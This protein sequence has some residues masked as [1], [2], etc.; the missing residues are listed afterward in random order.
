MI[1]GKRKAD[2]VY[3]DAD[4][5]AFLSDTP[6]V[7]GH[8]IIAP[9]RH[10]PIFEG[11]DDALTGKLFCAANRLSA[12][13]FSAIGAKGTN[14]IVNNGLAA[15]QEI[16]HFCVN[17]ISRQDG[18]GM[19]FDMMP[20]QLSEEEMAEVEIQLREGLKEKPR[21]K[22]EPAKIG[23]D[24]KSH[25]DNVSGGD[26]DKTNAGKVD[27][28]KKKDSRAEEENYLVKQLRRMP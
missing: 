23:K 24:D 8:I 7:V 20:K 13:A 25:A 19:I 26:D 22:N 28:E 5:I 14:L 18:D 10:S 11:L 4:I 2:I 21:L 27:D 6:A 9:K 17:I 12:A 16:P 15:G 1:T 3:D